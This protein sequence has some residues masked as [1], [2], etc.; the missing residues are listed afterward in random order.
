MVPVGRVGTIRARGLEALK[1]RIASVEPRLGRPLVD[2]ATW[3]QISVLSPIRVR[4]A[5][6][7]ADGA[8]LM[9]DA[10]HACHPHVAQGSTQAMEDGKVLAD[11]L[12]TCFSRGDFSASGLA[13][14]EG[15]RRPVVQRLQRVADEYAWL[16]ETES[17]TLA[18]LRDRIFRNIGDRPGLLS[19]VAATE[20]GIEARPLSFVERLQVLGLCP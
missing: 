19:R 3:E 9:G 11:V 17:P 8:A 13:R 7:V 6:W 2:L 20:A 10:A 4:A 16:W 1:S 12:E 14:Y 18:R 5:A 15:A